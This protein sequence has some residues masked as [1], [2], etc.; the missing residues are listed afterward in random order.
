MSW[1]VLCSL[2]VSCPILPM[3]KCF[4][5]CGLLYSAKKKKKKVMRML[6]RF[7]PEL[8]TYSCDGRPL[9]QSAKLDFNEAIVFI[10]SNP[11]ELHSQEYSRS[12]SK[13]DGWVYQH[14]GVPW[15]FGNSLK[16]RVKPSSGNRPQIRVGVPQ[17]KQS[18]WLITGLDPTVKHASQRQKQ[19]VTN[20]VLMGLIKKWAWNGGVY[21]RGRYCVSFVACVVILPRHALQ[22]L[23]MLA[24]FLSS[25]LM[26]K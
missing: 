8:N 1:K 16:V 2:P 5:S 11:Y 20:C 26:R 13:T 15:G 9:R 12:S 14:I 24:V 23:L 19:L 4:L 6:V 25:L 18:I 3:H 22:T 10:K 17:A 7:N 21:R